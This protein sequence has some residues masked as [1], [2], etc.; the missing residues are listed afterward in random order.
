MVEGA[1]AG[2]RGRPPNAVRV[3]SERA[4]SRAHRTTAYYGRWR[5]MI[6]RS[7]AGGW[8][9]ER[10]LTP[11]HKVSNYRLAGSNG[12]VAQ[13]VQFVESSEVE[14]DSD[15]L[16]DPH[17]GLRSSRGQAALKLMGQ[18]AADRAIW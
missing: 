5:A 12:P 10:S 17:N 15:R 18:E 16:L 9:H 7:A 3:A 6:R 11:N 2:I 13:A 14:V 1:P 8:I 4:S